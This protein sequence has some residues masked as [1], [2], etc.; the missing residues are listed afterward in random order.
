MFG[1]LL[2]FKAR[3]IPKLPEVRTT[4]LFL[5]SN[6][7]EVIQGSDYFCLS[8]PEPFRSCPMFGLLLS[9][10]ARTIP[11]LPDVRTTFVFQS[12]NHSEVT[13]GSDYF[14]LFKLEPFRSYPRFGLLLSF[15]ARTSPKLPD[16]RTTFVFQSQNHSEVA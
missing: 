7:S 5:S 2:S 15:K 4:F 12:Q 1:L 6:H 11:K 16:V 3:T 9:L 14:S 13:K 10:K 8:K